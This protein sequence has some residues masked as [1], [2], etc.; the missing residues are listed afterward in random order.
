MIKNI[1][2]NNAFTERNVSQ[3]V[4]FID[5]YLAYLIIFLIDFVRLGHSVIK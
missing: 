4:F 3:F 5:N 2:R 1:F